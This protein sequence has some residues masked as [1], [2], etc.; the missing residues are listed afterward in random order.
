MTLPGSPYVTRILGNGPTT[1]HDGARL[2]LHVKS[3][4]KMLQ[5]ILVCLGGLPESNQEII[6]VCVRAIALKPIRSWQAVKTV[7]PALTP[8]TQQLRAPTSFL[9]ADFCAAFA[10]TTISRFHSTGD[11][12]T[13]HRTRGSPAVSS[14]CC[15]LHAESVSRPLW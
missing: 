11:T 1:M 7:V 5:G 9:E 8:Q 13:E 6:D 3:V 15:E 10:K 12:L 4:H 14:R 2:L